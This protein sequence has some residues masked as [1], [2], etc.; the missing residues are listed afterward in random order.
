[1]GQPGNQVMN[2]L[3]NSIFQKKK[4][5]LNQARKTCFQLK[6]KAQMNCEED[7][8]S[9]YTIVLINTLIW[10]FKEKKESSSYINLIATF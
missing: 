5:K 3:G 6:L 9:D 4:R 1:M 10:I 2:W 7:I 8:L